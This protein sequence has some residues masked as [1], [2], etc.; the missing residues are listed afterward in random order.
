[1][2]ADSQLLQPWGSLYVIYTA[3]QVG[4]SP[5]GDWLNSLSFPIDDYYFHALDRGL[6]D[7]S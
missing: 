3:Q 5:L 4:E 1:M 7:S 2:G 6:L